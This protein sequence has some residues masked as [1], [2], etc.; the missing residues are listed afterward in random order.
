MFIEWSKI[1]IEIT[2]S[3]NPSALKPNQKIISYISDHTSFA[4]STGWTEFEHFFLPDF[5]AG[6]PKW[7]P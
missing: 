7:D 2:Q 1:S 3:P 5:P 6:C 4:G